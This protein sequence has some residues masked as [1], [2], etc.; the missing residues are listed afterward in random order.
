ME[1]GQLLLDTVIPR[2]PL[3]EVAFQPSK[4]KSKSV[5]SMPIKESLTRRMRCEFCTHDKKK[6]G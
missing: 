3:I 1:F 4:K 2:Y 6:M 5:F